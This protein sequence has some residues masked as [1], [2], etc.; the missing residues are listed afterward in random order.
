MGL[1]RTRGLAAEAMAAAYLELIG[2]EMIARNVRMHGVEVDLVARED[3]T[4][5]LVEVKWR[6]RS[7]YGGAALA[8]DHVKRRRLL[9]AA[10][11]AAAERSG[12]L[13]IDVVAIELSSEGAAV[14]HYRNA[15]TE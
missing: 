4:H 7:D 10:H 13:R 5:V 12:P 14:R 1:A 8:V 11:H 2:C 6:N 9:R 3:R 15:V